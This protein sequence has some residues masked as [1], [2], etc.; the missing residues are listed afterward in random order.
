MAACFVMPIPFVSDTTT[1]ITLL[2]LGYFCSQMPSGVIWT[3]A[4]DM[5]PKGQVASLGYPELWWFPRS[6]AGTDRHR[7]H[8]G[9]D[10]SVHQCLYSWRLSVVY[11]RLFLRLLCA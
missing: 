2:T 8:S 7:Y 11:G 10:R 6:R 9:C 5:A 4:T 3:L 1:A